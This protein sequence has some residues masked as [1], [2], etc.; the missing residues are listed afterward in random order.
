M[1]KSTGN[2]GFHMV[3]SNGNTISV[4]YGPGNYCSKRSDD[5]DIRPLE[6]IKWSSEDAEIAIWNDKGT[7]Y[8][9]GY[10]QVKGWCA[11]DEVAE[12]IAKTASGQIEFK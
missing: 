11:A 2:R 5:L 8:D 12:W 9:F 4:Q 6:E 7:W 1:F 3:F 10:D